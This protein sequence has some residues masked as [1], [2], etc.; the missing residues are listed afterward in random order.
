MPLKQKNKNLNDGMVVKNDIDLVFTVK[1]C[2]N[3]NSDEILYE[4]NVSFI[5]SKR[6]KMMKCTENIIGNLIHG[7]IPFKDLGVGYLAEFSRKPKEYYNDIFLMLLNIHS[8]KY[9]N[10][11]IIDSE[12]Y[13]HQE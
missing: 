3:N 7:N 11:N 10:C 2:K 5:N 6:E 12:E 9:F 4:K 1:I 13:E 8:H